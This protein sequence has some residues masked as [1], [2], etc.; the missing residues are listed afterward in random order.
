MGGE[1]D[2]QER[3]HRG[4]QAERVPVADGRG[5]A[6]PA[7]RRRREVVGEEPRREGEGAHARHR[8]HGPCQEVWDLVAPHDR[9]HGERPR[10]EDEQALDLERRLARRLAP[11]HGQ[12]R[13]G[14][15]EG[16]ATHE[17]EL[18][19]RRPGGGAGGRDDRRRAGQGHRPPAPGQR[20][21]APVGRE[22]RDEPQAQGNGRDARQDG[23][24]VPQESCRGRDGH[25]PPQLRAT[26][27]S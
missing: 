6:V 13:P 24:A 2:G 16:Q 23:P 5:E 26:F 22:Q 3:G 14:G 1:G 21:V 25:V 11:Q 9:L 19:R 8:R 17:H 12:R 27:P 18:E 10:D 4:H 15:E 7:E 20:E